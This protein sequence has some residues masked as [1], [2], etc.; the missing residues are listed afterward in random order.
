MD[1]MARSESEQAL[2]QTAK[3]VISFAKLPG[4]FGSVG[5]LV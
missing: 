5:R 1:M 4:W 3:R 2:V